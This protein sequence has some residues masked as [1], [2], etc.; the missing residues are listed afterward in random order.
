MVRT[1]RVA[2]IEVILDVVFNHTAETDENGPT[3]SFRVIDKQSYYRIPENDRSSYENFS[4]YDN[5]L[6]LAHPGTLQMVMDALR[7]WM[8][9]C[10]SRDSALT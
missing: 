5:T 7:Y 2:G 10:M 6:N 4:G 1:L 8:S 3:I 9:E